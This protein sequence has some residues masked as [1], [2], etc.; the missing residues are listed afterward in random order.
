VRIRQRKNLPNKAN[1]QKLYKKSEKRHRER[2]IYKKGRKQESWNGRI[3]KKES[4]NERK[5]KR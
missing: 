5:R 1:D 3:K 2:G 4:V